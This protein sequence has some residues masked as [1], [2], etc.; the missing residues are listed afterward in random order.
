MFLPGQ[1]PRQ[2]ASASTRS[3]RG[4]SRAVALAI[5]VIPSYQASDA[6]ARLRNGRLAWLPGCGHLAHVERP[7]RFVA[8]VGRFLADVADGVGALR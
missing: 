7:D 3:T 2:I 1:G 8:V 6:A 4:S 5:L